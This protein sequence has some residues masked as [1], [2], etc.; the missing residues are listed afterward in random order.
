MRSLRLSALVLA[1]ALAGCSTLKVSTEYDPT[2]PYATYKTYAWLA[3]TP[4]PEQ[5]PPIRNPVVAAQVMAAV[6]REMKAKGLVLTKLEE[7]PDFLV[8]VHGWSQSRIEVTN[9]GYGYAGTYAYGYGPYR[10]VMP[11]GSTAVDTYTDGTMLLDLVDAKTKKLVWRG[12]ASDTFSSP[13]PDSV[14]K[15][16][17]EA[18]RQLMGAYPPKTK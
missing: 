5:A 6:D 3:V 10:P 8:T 17:D 7:N 1:A 13:T 4:G 15:A 11:V 14:K 12:T 9:Y 18:V 2:A 16:V